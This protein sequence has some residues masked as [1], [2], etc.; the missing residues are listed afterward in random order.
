MSSPWPFYG[1][2]PHFLVW[3]RGTGTI[4]SLICS[5]PGQSFPAGAR[6][7]S[8]D[9]RSILH[10]LYD[11]FASNVKVFFFSSESCTWN[12]KSQTILKDCNEKI[13][14]LCLP[15]PTPESHS[16]EATTF[17]SSVSSGIHFKF[18]KY[19]T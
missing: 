6:L 1:F 12:S 11:N 3:H 15:F 16:P 18:S 10:L 7:V 17:N 2:L 14:A 9:P 13:A 5:L 4:A 8:S 19:Y